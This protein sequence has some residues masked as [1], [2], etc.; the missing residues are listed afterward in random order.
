[1]Q[2]SKLDDGLA[3]KLPQ[4]VVDALGLK[5]GDEVEVHPIVRW[6]EAEETIRQ[7][8]LRRIRELSFPFPPDFKFDRLEANER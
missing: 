8:A 2:V 6:T 7:E 5:E 3:V 1:M 4:S